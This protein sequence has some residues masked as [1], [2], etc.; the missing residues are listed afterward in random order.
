ML[1]FGYALL[2]FTLGGFVYSVLN[3]IITG[4][5]N[6]YDVGQVFVQFIEI[7]VWMEKES[8]ITE[9]SERF[10]RKFLVDWIKTIEPKLFK[11]DIIKFDT[12]EEMVI[13]EREIN[14]SKTFKDKK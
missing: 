11:K 2:W 10:V 7:V 9:G 5:K 1:S 12:W 4:T 6:L 8:N 13:F 3:R 14:E